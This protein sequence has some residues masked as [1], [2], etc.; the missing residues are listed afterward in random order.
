MSYPEPDPNL[1]FVYDG[2]LEGLLCA[3]FATYARKQVP[4]DIVA[5]DDAQLRLGQ[6]AH[7]VATSPL[8]A[9]RVRAGIVRT[10]GSETYAAVRAAS[11]S[12]EADK[13]IVITRFVRH[14][15]AAKRSTL[16]QLSHPQVEPFIHIHRS[17]LNERHRMMQF[18]R[19]QELEGGFWFA[20]CSPQ[21]NVVPLLM[22]W[23]AER[24]NVQ[25]FVIYDEAHG[26]A[27]VYQG[28]G[29]FLVE[30]DELDL[31]DPTADERA[32]AQAWRRF[33]ETASIEARL[34]P[35]LRRSFMPK[36]LWKHITELA[37]E[38]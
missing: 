10:C 26:L 15:M 27:G 24:F 29:W 37:D 9:E 8:I 31:P 20:R 7:T 2:T 12:D 4:L 23:F 33:Y 38:C 32:M 13:G 19:F 25:P 36:R 34:N 21:A 22:D 3:V 18:L 16:D 6:E 5:A 17:V 28:H 1:A 11:L 30:T 14:S 35:E